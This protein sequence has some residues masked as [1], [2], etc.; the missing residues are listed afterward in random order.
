MTERSLGQSEWA[1]ES[2]IR[3]VPGVN[4]SRAVALAAQVVG[5]EAAVLAVAIWYNLPRAAIAGTVAV[6]VALVGSVFMLRLSRVI[7]REAVPIAYRQVLFGSRIE[8]VLGLLAFCLLQTYVFVYDP[9]HGSESLLTAVL[10]EEPP[11]VAVF[12]FL[13]I[14]WDLAYRIGVGWWASVVGLWRSYHYRTTLSAS[15]RARLRRIDAVTIGFGAVQ[16]LF[17]PLLAGH[18]L[19]QYLLVGHTA[20]ITLVSGASIRLLR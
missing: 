19:L 13:V 11:V 14:G 2:I 8:I 17:V 7:R 10:G 5:F 9:R 6:V 15:V 1:Y 12:L 20:A 16:L 4:T 18:P 3:S